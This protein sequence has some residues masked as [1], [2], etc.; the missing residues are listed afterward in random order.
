MVGLFAEHR[1][2]AFLNDKHGKSA[3]DRPC[4]DMVSDNERSEAS[5]KSPETTLLD[6]SNFAHCGDPSWC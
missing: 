3:I 6:S 1:D 4:F 5:D 2:R